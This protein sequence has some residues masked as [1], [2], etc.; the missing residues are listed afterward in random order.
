MNAAQM[1]TVVILAA[2]SLA[3]CGGNS[4]EVSSDFEAE[5]AAAAVEAAAECS[6]KP[7]KV[8]VCHIPPGNPDN[9]HSICISENAV[10]THVDHHGDTIGSSCEALEDPPG[11]E[12]PPEGDDDDGDGD[13][14]TPPSNGDPDD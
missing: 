2:V 12:A 13:T 7:H 14:R 8:L 9:W 6:A 10:D 3:S 1:N 5:R 4:G 11:D